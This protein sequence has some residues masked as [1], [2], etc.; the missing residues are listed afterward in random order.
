MLNAKLVSERIRSAQTLP[1]R[2]VADEEG[3]LA[4]TDAACCAIT[5]FELDFPITVDMQRPIEDA[6]N[7]MIRLGIHALLVTRLAPRGIN[8]SIEGLITARDIQSALRTFRSL[9]QS[10]HRRPRSLPVGEV[11]TAWDDLSMVKYES[12]QCLTAI[13]LYEMF[14]GTGL[15]HL[16]VID[17]DDGDVA[18]VRGLLSRATLAKRLR[19]S[20]AQSLP[21]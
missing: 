20:R 7:D 14:Q 5:D 11:M 9:N 21:P 12:L 17:L 16:L 15:T 8:P 13:D 3:Y 1:R 10:T 18:T 4:A 6:F 2:I 19:R